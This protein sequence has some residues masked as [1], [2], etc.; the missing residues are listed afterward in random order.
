MARTNGTSAS[1]A[2]RPGEHEQLAARAV[3]DLADRAGDGAVRQLGAQALQLVDVEL[4][5]VV[6]RRESRLP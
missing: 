2:L 4:V 5:G 1:G 6:R 3:H